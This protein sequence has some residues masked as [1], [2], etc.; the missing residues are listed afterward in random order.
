MPQLLNVYSTPILIGNLLKATPLSGIIYTQE[1]PETEIVAPTV[2]W[3]VESSVNGV[4]GKETK[5]PRLRGM[6]WMDGHPEVIVYFGQAMTTV[7]QFDLLHKTN[8]EVNKLH[9]QFKQFIDEARPALCAHGVSQF[10]FDQQ[11]R[12]PRVKVPEHCS[13][14]SLRYSVNYTEYTPVVESIV[15]DLLIVVKEDMTQQLSGMTRSSLAFDIISPNYNYQYMY[16]IFDQQDWTIETGANYTKGIDYDVITFPDDEAT[17][18]IHWLS[19]GRKPTEGA[20]Y[21]ILYAKIGS[22]SETSTIQSLTK[23]NI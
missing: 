11:L 15:N 13:A 18:V 16:G 1:F 23:E 19:G 8:G 5:K 6:E 2:V 9:L 12:D 17:K 21:Y 10:I 22:S 7:Y 20:T 14:R 3:H 4:E